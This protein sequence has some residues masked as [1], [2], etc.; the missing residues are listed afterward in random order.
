MAEQ[1]PRTR[2]DKA[3]P[4]VIRQ[5]LG[6]ETNRRFLGG[7]TAFEA[8]CRVPDRLLAL[9]NELDRADAKHHSGR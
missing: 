9:L 4:E 1:R 5:E 6:S 2:Q 3:L 7:M 8:D